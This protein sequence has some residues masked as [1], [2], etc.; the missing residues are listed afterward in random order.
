MDF[1]VFTMLGMLGQN[2]N[3]ILNTFHGYNA[4]VS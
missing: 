4:D 2:E 1:N 3:E